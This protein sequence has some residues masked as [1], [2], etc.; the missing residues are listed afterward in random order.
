MTAFKKWVVLAFLNFSVGENFLLQKKF[1][2]SVYSV[3]VTA[4]LKHLLD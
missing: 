1:G 4:V 2:W 3:C